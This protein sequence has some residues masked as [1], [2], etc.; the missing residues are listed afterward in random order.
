[1]PLSVSR[2]SVGDSGIDQELRQVLADLGAPAGEDW[3][4]AVSAAT[5]KAAWE[6]VMEGAPRNKSEHVGWEILQND[7]RARFRK[8]F[9]GREEK[10]VEAFK[11]AARK[12]VWESV[13][14][15]ENPIRAV[16]APL[17]ESFEDAVWNLLRH[18]DMVPVHVRFGVWREGPDGMKY[19]C[20]VEYSSAR[21]VPWS[22]WS[23]LVRTP[24]D[25]AV[26]LARALLQ[27]RKRQYVC[28]SALAAL[29]RRPA[30]RPRTT[31]SPAAAA[32]ASRAAAEERAAI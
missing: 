11:R 6:V 3:T 17:G 12:L 19:V 2:V 29:R 27:R 18:E 9:L 15:R 1:M 22:W 5:P 23:G 21:K 16:S 13:Q 31:P 26:E 30:R 20:K 8:L 4:A 32:A 25:L 14:F 10:S 28:P 7:G 24:S